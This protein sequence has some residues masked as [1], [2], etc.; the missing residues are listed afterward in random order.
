MEFE[1]SSLIPGVRGV[2]VREEFDFEECEEFEEFEEFDFRGV[3][4]VGVR[5]EFV[6]VGVR[7]VRGVR[8]F[9]DPRSS[10]ELEFDR[11]S[12]ST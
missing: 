6:V 3:R 7:G 9:A 8:E 2:G 11:S 12:L 10:G 5:Q 4:G 1:R